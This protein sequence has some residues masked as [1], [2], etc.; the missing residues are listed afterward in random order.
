[1]A[2]PPSGSAQKERI[3]FALYCADGLPTGFLCQ[4]ANR[5]F[6]ATCET[7]RGVKAS[8]WYIPFSRMTTTDF[9]KC[10]RIGETFWKKI[11]E[12][13]RKASAACNSRDIIGAGKSRQM[14]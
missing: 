5:L 10:Q 1:M 12:K 14:I 2:H 3:R 6:A 13:K 4:S 9:L 7:E 8:R 11:F